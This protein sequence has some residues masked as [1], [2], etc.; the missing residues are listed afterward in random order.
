MYNP[1]K[2]TVSPHDVNVGYL[3]AAHE[4]EAA[5]RKNSSEAHQSIA[6]EQRQLPDNSNLTPSARLACGIHH[7]PLTVAWREI[8]DGRERESGEGGRGGGVGG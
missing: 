8:E 7:R 2:Q 5:T 4:M 1:F 6:D 3:T